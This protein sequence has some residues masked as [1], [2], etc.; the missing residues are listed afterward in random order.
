MM[1]R[2]LQQA[3]GR[4]IALM[5]GGNLG[6]IIWALLALAGLTLNL[7]LWLELARRLLPAA[8][9]VMIYG[10]L[11]AASGFLAYVGEYL[12]PYFDSG[13]M[14]AAGWLNWI[15]PQIQSAP[16]LVDR[17]LQGGPFPWPGYWP[18]LAQCLPLAAALRFVSQRTT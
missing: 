15:L 5:G 12:A 16:A 7:S 17:Y 4:P 8:A 13:A 3:G 18:V 6:P 1:L 10:G 9:T 11:W 14:R 2:R